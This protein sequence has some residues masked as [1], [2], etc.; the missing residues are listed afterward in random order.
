MDG[1]HLFTQVLSANSPPFSLVQSIT[2]LI[3]FDK[4]G[5]PCC[6]LGRCSSELSKVMTWDSE[7]SVLDSLSSDEGP[8]YV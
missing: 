7:L 8:G 3:T 1:F 5:L 2:L 6:S 4:L